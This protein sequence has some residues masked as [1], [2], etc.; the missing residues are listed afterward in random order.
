MVLVL[1]V[2]K[3]LWDQSKIVFI[4]L[5]RLTESDLL[6]PLLNLMFVSFKLLSR[7]RKIV[8]TNEV[9]C[10]IHQ[11]GRIRGR[12]GKELKAVGVV[13][14]CWCRWDRRRYDNGRHHEGRL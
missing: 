12:R 9:A 5:G 4:S 10:N 11:R 8:R 2:T 14:V 1:F 7:S 3:V 6:Q 13:G